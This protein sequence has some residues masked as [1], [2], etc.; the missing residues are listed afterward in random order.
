MVAPQPPSSICAGESYYKR[1]FEASMD[2][3][4]QRTDP[5]TVDDAQL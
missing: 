1:S 5:F 4:A 2:A 3:C